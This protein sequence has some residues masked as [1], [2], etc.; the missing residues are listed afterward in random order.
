[1][2]GPAL[3]ARLEALAADVGRL[4]RRFAS[5]DDAWTGAYVVDRIAQ[6][7][8]CLDSWFSATA[9]DIYSENLIHGASE[10]EAVAHAF[11]VV[12]KRARHIRGLLGEEPR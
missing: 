8:E 1:M 3:L 10:D 9:A 12:D 7:V 5:N 4:R 2:N 6:H 11:A